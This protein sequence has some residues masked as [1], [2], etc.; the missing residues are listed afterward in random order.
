MLV[1]SP[2]HGKV[3]FECT[4]RPAALHRFEG[5]DALEHASLKYNKY[6]KGI[7]PH[8]LDQAAAYVSKRLR[9]LHPPRY[10]RVFTF[11][12]AIEGI[13]GERFLGPVPRKTSAGL[14]WNVLWSKSGKIDAMGLEEKVDYDSEEMKRVRFEV[15][16]AVRGILDN[17]RP[18]F[19]FTSFLKDELRPI[20]KAAR[21]ISSAPFHLSILMRQYFL[22]FSEHI[23]NNRIING[24]AVGINP[25][26]DEWT[27]LGRIHDKR[28]VVA[29]DYSSFDCCMEPNA[30]ARIKT[31][32]HEFYN[33]FDTPE[34]KIRDVLFDELIYSRHAFGEAVYEWIGCNPSGNVL[35]AI[36]NSLM[37]L[38]MV[39]SARFEIIDQSDHHGDDGVDATTYG[40][41][42]LIS[43]NNPKFGFNAFQRVFAKWD[44][45]F[46][47]EDKKD[48]EHFADKTIADVSFLKRGFLRVSE[49]TD[50]KFV[51]ALSLDTIMNCVQ[52]M[53]KNDHDFADF[54]NRVETMLIEL[55]AHGPNVYYYWQR[56]ICEAS[57][58]SWEGPRFGPMEW[59]ARFELFLSS[60]ASY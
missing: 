5:K 8:R 35:T 21:L 41:D 30:M 32:I 26:G 1:K 10:A 44:I 3:R 14:P 49:F 33:D 23:M 29:G 24:V 40:D 51:A 15:D 16:W 56:A 47:D 55:S 45:K 54:R 48:A 22:G 39:H 60:D 38:M 43:S 9:G 27:L 34:F 4:Q 17:I 36:I 50:K 59:K 18:V 42:V 6:V 11:E 20:G 57:E 28:V 12:E 13:P 19:I 58:A 7:P 52:W 2:L 37:S 46:T 25:M 31:M 53:R